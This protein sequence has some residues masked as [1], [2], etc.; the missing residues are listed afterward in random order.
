ML[1]VRDIMTR[2]VVTLAPESTIREAMETLST[3][4]LSGAPVVSG[5][6]VVGVIS[7][8]DIL[9]LIVSGPDPVSPDQGESMV[10]SWERSDDE[11]EDDEDIQTAAVS[12]EVWDEWADDSGSIVDTAS[13]EGYKLLDQCTV[14]EAMN[15][16]LF[17]LQASAS[18]RAAATM[19]RERGIHRVIVMDGKSVVGIVSALDIARAVS[20]TGLAGIKVLPTCDEPSPWITT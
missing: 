12:D 3:N 5:E 6:S 4:H 11:L 15:R 16:E 10:E 7:M 1:R 14:E 20:E 17:S 2:E 9:G 13:P 19:M 8:S 18:V